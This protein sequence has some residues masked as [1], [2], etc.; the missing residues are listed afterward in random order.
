[1]R[2]NKG[3]IQ[4]VDNSHHTKGKHSLWHPYPV[5]NGRSSKCSGTVVL[6]EPLADTCILAEADS[7]WGCSG[8]RRRPAVPP[9]PGEP[10]PPR[11]HSTPGAG[12]VAYTPG[13]IYIPV[14]PLSSPQSRGTP[15][16]QREQTLEDSGSFWN[17]LTKYLLTICFTN[18]LIDF[19]RQHLAKVVSRP[20]CNLATFLCVFIQAFSHFVHDVSENPQRNVFK[21]HKSLTNSWDATFRTEKRISSWIWIEFE[22]TGCGIAV[23]IWMWGS[24]I[25]IQRGLT[26]TFN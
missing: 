21:H 10:P 20:R 1:M 19:C 24:R 8:H 22:Q 9:D 13:L 3:Q 23:W 2:K 25:E 18:E 11:P 14:Q 6:R 15:A 7:S 26:V 16:P 5:E 17:Q 4:V 12:T